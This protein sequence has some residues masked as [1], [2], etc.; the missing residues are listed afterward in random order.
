MCPPGSLLL[1][2]AFE[3]FYVPQLYFLTSEDVGYSFLS[4]AIT[5]DN[6]R[7]R[8]D[9]L[10]PVQAAPPRVRVITQLFI[11]ALFGTWLFID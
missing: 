6:V 4:L 1:S 3:A 9:C 5:D 7:H 2:Q 10:G 8:S 11:S